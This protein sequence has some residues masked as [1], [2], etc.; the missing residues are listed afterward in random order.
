MRVFRAAVMAVFLAGLMGPA[1]AQDHMQQ[2]GEADKDKGFGEIQDEK[3]AA[4]AYKR[5][6]SN[7]PDQAAPTDPWGGARG[8]SAAPGGSAGKTS[9]KSARK[10]K[11]TR[12]GSN[13]N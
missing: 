7:I 11:P 1:F 13:T 3:A 10:T 8:A 9:A 5:S 2:Y 12:T 4:Q 6:L